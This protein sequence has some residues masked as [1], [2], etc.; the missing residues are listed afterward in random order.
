VYVKHIRKS[1]IEQ[2]NKETGAEIVYLK[3]PKGQKKGGQQA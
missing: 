3:A 2:I 1:E